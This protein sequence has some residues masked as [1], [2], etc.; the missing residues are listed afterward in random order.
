MS[1]RWNVIQQRPAMSTRESTVQMVPYKSSTKR[2]KGGSVGGRV[3]RHP[4]NAGAPFPKTSS[5]SLDDDR[6]STDSEIDGLDGLQMGSVRSRV[7]SRWFHL[8]FGTWIHFP[9]PPTLGRSQVFGMRCSA[10]C[11]E[12]VRSMTDGPQVPQNRWFG[13]AINDAWT[14]L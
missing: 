10:W 3:E 7:W 1:S 13:G 11:I 14:Y 6:A 9:T 5:S 8:S 4:I 2:A 12:S